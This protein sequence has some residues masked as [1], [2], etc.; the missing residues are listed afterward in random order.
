MENDNLIYE[1][2]LNELIRICLR[3][4]YLF[5]KIKYHLAG[6]TNWDSHNIIDSILNITELLDRPDYKSKFTHEI[7]RH[8]TKLTQLQHNP[9]VNPQQ[10]EY[11]STQLRIIYDYLHNHNGKLANQLRHN[12][13]LH[14]I[15]QQLRSP[16]GICHFDAPYYH[17]WL[18]QPF[19]KRQH[20]IDTW[21][22]ELITIQQMTHLLLYLTRENAKKTV[23]TAQTGFYQETFS[24]DNTFQLIRIS[25]PKHISVY[26]DLSVGRHRLALRFMQHNSQGRALQTTDDIVFELACC[27]SFTN[28]STNDYIVRSRKFIP[29]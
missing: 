4:E 8:R 22:N 17:F 29:I 16:V 24:Q 19:A 14:S 12:E 11:I 10:L 15:H 13:F 7:Q 2:P 6:Q 26:P 23:R 27:N 25:I 21:L 9:Q 5:N 20:D 3:L 28:Q 1:Q 18:H